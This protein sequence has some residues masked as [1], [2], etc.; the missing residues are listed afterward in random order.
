[1]S[2]TP[3]SSAM[4][5][6]SPSVT[7]SQALV[8]CWAM[9]HLTISPSA[10]NAILSSDTPR[11]ALVEGC[12]MSHNVIPSDLSLKLSFQAFY[13][14]V[15]AIIMINLLI[16]VMN[17]TFSEVWQTADKK[18][19][20]SRSYYQVLSQ[21]S[22]KITPLLRLTSCERNLRSRHP[23]SQF[24]TSRALSVGA[25]QKLQKRKWWWM[26]SPS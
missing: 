12:A 17:N 20:Y 2:E 22:K 18:W 15:V 5:T 16:A 21:I 11:Y 24:T 23:F 13:Q 14:L 1:M 4:N 7:P 8:E 9:P 10:I 25:R 19:K 26:W 3:T 6:I